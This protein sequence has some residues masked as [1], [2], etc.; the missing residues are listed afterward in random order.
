M[1]EELEATTLPEQLEVIFAISRLVVN[2][3]AA[4]RALEKLIPLARKLL[5]FDNF[6]IYENR[7]SGLEPVYARIVGR[8][9]G[10]NGEIA[11]GEAIAGEVVSKGRRVL[12]HEKLEDWRENRLNL[13][14]M[15]GL[16]LLSGEETV[17]AL[18]L[19]RF[20][21][22][23]FT[24]DHIRMAEMLAGQVAQ[25]LVHQRLYERLSILEAGRLLRTEQ[26]NFIATI[27]H[28]LCSPLGFIK[29][30]TTTLL[31]KDA[32]WDDETRREFLGIID[33]ESDRLRSLIDNLLDSS[34]LQSGTLR[35]QMQQTFIPDLLADVH[36]RVK[37]LYPG[38]ELQAQALD[39]FAIW[40][41]PLRLTQVLENLIGN[42]VKYAGGS[43]VWLEARLVEE[44]PVECSQLGKNLGRLTVR[45]QG[46]GI[47]AE[48]LERI[49]ER[50]Y[51]VPSTQ[52]MA[53]GTGLGLYICR[54]IVQTHGGCI[55][56]ESVENEGSAFH[57]Y[58]PVLH[59]EDAEQ[60]APVE[61]A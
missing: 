24:A 59:D 58:F 41:D 3:T 7:D 40:G 17:G 61:A 32:S 49:F 60:P 22:P 42:A 6:V 31:R 56:V 2:E 55:T 18:V 23:V 29:G 15:L 39:E 10:T 26:E 16:P 27:S 25:I 44:P 20:G 13:R 33:E 43:P 54:E 52:S 19:G 34:R 50:F 38:L 21:G 1:P 47:A 45:D 11:W 48:H 14:Y 37:I 28:E 36:N 57:L 53:H 30:Y 35:M 9:Q 8:G 4:D 5:I 46:P 51:R 12:Q